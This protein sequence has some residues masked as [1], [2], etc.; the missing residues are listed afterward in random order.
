MEAM[1]AESRVDCETPVNCTDEEEEQERVNHS[2]PSLICIC[3]HFFLIC[4]Y[5]FLYL[6]FSG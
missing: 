1:E 5:L 2:L 4:A 3:L 6:F